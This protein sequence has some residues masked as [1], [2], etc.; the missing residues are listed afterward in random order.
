MVEVV[1][2]VEVVEQQHHK[3]WQSGNHHLSVIDS[4]SMQRREAFLIQLRQQKSAT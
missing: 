3:S 1:E 4:I 2:V